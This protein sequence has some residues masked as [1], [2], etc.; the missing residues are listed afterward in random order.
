MLE[1]EKYK[2]STYEV[3]KVIKHTDASIV[4]V[5]KNTIDEKTYIKKTYPSD[6]RV[7]FNILTKIDIPSIPKIFE[8]FFGTDTIVIEEYIEGK[9]IK[10]LIEE[11][12]S[13]TKKEIHY[14]FS[15]LINAV[16]TLHSYNIIHRDIKPGNIIVK[17]NG[18]AVLIDYN[19]ARIYSDKH[20]EDTELL[21]TIGY[22][23]PEQFGF[24]QTDYRSDIYALGMTVKELINR[25]N[26][27]KQIANIIRR[28]C[29]F[30]PSKRFQT[31]P[32]LKKN[33]QIKKIE[34][35]ICLVLI[36]FAFAVSTLTFFGNSQKNISDD[37]IHIKEA[38]EMAS[39][40]SDEENSPSVQDEVSTTQEVTVIQKNESGENINKNMA[41]AETKD[42]LMEKPQPTKKVETVDKNN[43]N[44]L[45]YLPT[46]TRIVD[47]S[48]AAFNIPCLQL[49]G[50]STYKVHIDI[51][52]E[53][54]DILVSATKDSNGLSITIDK[55]TTYYC[56]KDTSLS[57]ADYPNGELF[58]EIL[59]Y[60]INND[61]T[62][63]IIP[64]LCDAVSTKWAN[65]ETVLLKNYS[66]GWCIYNDGE[67]YKLAK[68]R[69]LSDM[70][71]FKIYSS[72]PSCV[73]TD[74]PMHYKFENGSIVK[75]S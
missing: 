30:D 22:A 74:F 23:A 45:T 55:N 66:L 59:F 50:N 68:G 13:F 72:S 38:T 75:N 11:N 6:K 56:P 64:I 12:H 61:G 4:E 24:S 1:S 62:K 25:K 60:D 3:V 71:G 8:V 51:S 54:K 70:E 27:P 2:L 65:G 31:I 14:I 40:N 69:M 52:D 19:I 39:N 17:E 73:W 57:T 15:S 20:T 26:A 37:M 43:D 9:T 58:A 33:L 47:T 41:V 21:G 36:I 32:Q 28:C 63:E 42:S 49:T 7:I 29:E 48:Q 18:Q 34:S 35:A 46:S 53:L 16:D 44:Q 5:V 10:Q 67:S